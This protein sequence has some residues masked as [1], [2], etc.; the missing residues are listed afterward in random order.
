MATCGG[1]ETDKDTTARTKYDTSCLLKLKNVE[2]TFIK[3]NRSLYST[4]RSMNICKRFC[5]K[6]GKRGGKLIKLGQKKKVPV[7]SMMLANLRSMQKKI[8]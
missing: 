4:L 1:H 8:P 5:R 6:R 7:P 3:S 2:N